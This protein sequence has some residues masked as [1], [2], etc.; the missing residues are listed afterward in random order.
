MKNKDDIEQKAWQTFTES[1]KVE[2]Y[3]NYNS[4]KGE[5]YGNDKN[6]G[7]S[8]FGDGARRTR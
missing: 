6:K 8:G 4:L 2:D 3:L 1:G 5:A 7:D